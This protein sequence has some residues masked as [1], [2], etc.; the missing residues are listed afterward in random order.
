MLIQTGGVAIGS[1]RAAVAPDHVGVVAWETGSSG[2]AEIRVAGIGPEAPVD[3]APPA[4]APITAPPPVLVPPAKPKGRLAQKAPKA[5]RISR[6]R[7]RLTLDGKLTRPAGVS[8]AQGCRGSI[9]ATVRRGKKRIARKALPLSQ[10][11]RFHR[12]GVLGRKKVKRA[13]KLGVTL[14]FAGNPALASVS[15]SYKVKVRKR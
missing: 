13:R 1:L 8:A 2:D 14:R 12:V 4:A 6:G 15:R 9:V 5:K 11:C 3:P 7:V 10:S